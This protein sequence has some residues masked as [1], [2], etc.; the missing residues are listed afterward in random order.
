[1]LSLKHSRL[2]PLLNN[3]FVVA[4]LIS[5]FFQGMYVS[6]V[7]AQ[8]AP[9]NERNQTNNNPADGNNDNDSGIDSS[10]VAAAAAIA[11]A[12]IT[13][14]FTLINQR[15]IAS[16]D[17]R[18]IK[19]DARTSYEYAAKK[20]LYE[21]FEPI[22]FQL[23]E[24][25]N[26][27]Y[28]RIIGLAQE[29]S[30]GRLKPNLGNMSS[31]NSYYLKSTIYRLIA[32]MAAFR[33]IQCQL[34]MV[35]LSLDPFISIQYEIAKAIYHTFSADYNILDLVK[36]DYPKF[37]YEPQ[38]GK[39][40]TEVEKTRLR[41]I[42]PAKYKRQAIFVGI[43]EK[44]VDGLIVYDEHLK[45][46]RILRYGEFEE[47]YF[48]EEKPAWKNKTELLKIIRLLLDFHPKSHSIFWRILMTQALLYKALKTIREKHDPP[49]I[50]YFKSVTDDEKR[51][52]DWREN[53]SEATDE[54]VLNQPL[55]IAE[56]Y[57]QTYERTL[58]DKLVNG[59]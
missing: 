19:E 41:Q 59:I 36:K 13:G 47:K 4:M 26:Y 31:L 51:L 45:K 32:P 14:L 52:F 22:L 40:Y 55:S 33:L 53:T 25:S 6:F 21:E 39:G 34:T 42:N 58:Y 12:I 8:E 37:E 1:M 57:L 2:F 49:Y 44:L 27:A 24:M 15:K 43:L 11:G 5:L 46:N 16:L 56:K 17:L 48:S 28:Y 35:D 20:R 38:L 30:E 18:K 23:V 54:E 10:Q 7:H 3:T 50:T 29:A 9:I